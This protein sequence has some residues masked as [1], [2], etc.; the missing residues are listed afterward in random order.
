MIL[1][2]ELR[3]SNFDFPRMLKKYALLL[4][5]LVLIRTLS[6]VIFPFF[7]DDIGDLLGIDMRILLPQSMTI[8]TYLVNIIA[9]IMLYLDMQ[10]ERITSYPIL[11]LAIFQTEAAVVLFLLLV[12]Y[13]RFWRRRD[14]VS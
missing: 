2:Q 5:I 1:D 7:Y 10:T 13:N 14:I 11:V 8:I 6:F 3:D 12:T 9:A 4:C